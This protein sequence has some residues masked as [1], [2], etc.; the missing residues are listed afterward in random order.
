MRLTGWPG[1]LILS[2]GISEKDCL[3]SLTTYLRA[4]AENNGGLQFRTQIRTR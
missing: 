3:I 1:D 2:V 4:V